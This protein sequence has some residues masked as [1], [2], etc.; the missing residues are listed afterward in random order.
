MSIVRNMIGE[1]KKDHLTD[2][3]LSKRVNP[4]VNPFF[5]QLFLDFFKTDVFLFLHLAALQAHLPD[6]DSPPLIFPRYYG[7]DA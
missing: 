3:S 2:D 7:Y 4:R 6:A 1:L 5:T